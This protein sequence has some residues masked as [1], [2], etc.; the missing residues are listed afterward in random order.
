MKGKTAV[1]AAAAGVC[2]VQMFLPVMVLAAAGGASQASPAAAAAAA[3]GPR[4]Q[5]A[6][7]KSASANEALGAK[8]AAG[9]GWTGQQDTCLNELWTKESGWSNTAKNAQSGAYGISQALGHLPGEA[10]SVT[11]A[12]LALNRAGDNFPVAAANPPPWGSSDPADQISW[13]LDYIQ[14]TYGS[15]CAAWAHE[16]TDGW[17]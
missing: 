10:K 16:T 2:A 4:G 9:R 12:D 17:Y 3:S 5:I 7:G 14:G 1:I 6:G 11:A 8:L 15:P 13:G